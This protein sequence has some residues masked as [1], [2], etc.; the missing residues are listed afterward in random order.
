[1]K[2]GECCDITRIVYAK[3][4]DP[5]KPSWSV[6]NVWSKKMIAE[7][8][9]TYEQVAEMHA[10]SPNPSGAV[11]KEPSSTLCEI[12]CRARAAVADEATQIPRP[13]GGR[14]RALMNAKNK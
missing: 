10:C 3:R 12:S 14:S 5:R 9:G 6:D 1:M 2:K 13:R 7:R 4:G 8:F 11:P